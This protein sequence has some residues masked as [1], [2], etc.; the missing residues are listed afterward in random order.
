M[1][2]VHGYQNEQEV[3]EA[4]T[5]QLFKHIETTRFIA[6]C[7]RTQR[8]KRSEIHT[9]QAAI[10]PPKRR[11]FLALPGDKFGRKMLDYWEK[12]HPTNPIWK[13]AA[14]YQ[15]HKRDSSPNTPNDYTWK[16]H[17]FFSKAGVPATQIH[18]IEQSG[19][20]EKNASIYALSLPHSRGLYYNPAYAFN[21][22]YATRLYESPFHCAICFI[23][24][25]GEIC[26]ATKNY[27]PFY[28]TTYYTV[29]LGNKNKG[30][31]LSAEALLDIPRLLLVLLEN[32]F[33]SITGSS[34]VSFILKNHHNVHLFS[35]IRN[36]E[37]IV[38][39]KGL[40]SLWF[41]EIRISR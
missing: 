35:N 25:S 19:N 7:I 27:P 16:E 38:K 28:G 20:V 1:I 26:F 15:T 23:D 41:Y 21:G 10:N 36:F 13:K 18:P 11:F 32:D 33:D 12:Y 9:P 31:T 22:D 4:V 30:I 8:R 29:E 34:T 2:W 39:E 6:P 40:D 14:Y 3:L 37:P 5:Q 17:P 24:R